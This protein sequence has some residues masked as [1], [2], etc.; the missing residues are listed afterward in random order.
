M[1]ITNF[2]PVRLLDPDCCYKSTYLVNSADL[3]QCDLVLHCLLRQDISGLRRTR[4]KE[5]YL[6]MILGSFSLFLYTS[7]CCGYSLEVPG[8]GISD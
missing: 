4:V 2:Q 7:I 1:P 8:L 6:I 3:D 5:G